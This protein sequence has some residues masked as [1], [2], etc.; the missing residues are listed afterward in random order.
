MRTFLLA[1]CVS[2][3]IPLSAY[4]VD[5]VGGGLRVV[6]VE[7]I[8]DS[9]VVIKLDNGNGVVDPVWVDCIS[10]EWGFEGSERGTAVKADQRSQAVAYRACRDI[11]YKSAVVQV[12]GA[13]RSE[14]QIIDPEKVPEPIIAR[15]PIE[16]GALT[17]LPVLAIPGRMLLGAI[18][19]WP[20]S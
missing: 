1:T 7:Q 20:E 15:V 6:S 13:W 8:D 14:V 2:V 9:K 12:A 10:A 3:F 17:T 5:L 19:V 18:R 16:E 4:A 11:P